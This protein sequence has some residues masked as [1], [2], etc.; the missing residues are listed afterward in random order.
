MGE[1]G[2]ARA[3]AGVPGSV[4]SP[5]RM[6]R[7][8]W[9]CGHPVRQSAGRDR[10]GRLGAVDRSSL[11]RVDTRLLELDL[12]VDWRKDAAVARTHTDSLCFFSYARIRKSCLGDGLVHALGGVSK[13]GVLLYRPAIAGI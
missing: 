10:H 9:Q 3:E 2:Y 11:D 5:A 4:C 6:G 7:R 12:C 1:V 13:S 8:R